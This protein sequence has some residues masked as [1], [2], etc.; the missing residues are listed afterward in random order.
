MQ[1]P[2]NW[3]NTPAQMG[4][5][6]EM[7]PP[8]GHIFKILRAFV[9]PNRNGNDMMEVWVDVAE[10]GQND[11][12]YRRNA[13]NRNMDIREKWPNDGIIYVNVYDKD[14]NANPRFKGFIKAVE[15]SNLSYAWNWDEMT[16]RGKL[17]G[18]I[19]RGEESES[20]TNGRIYTNCK[21]I[22]F[23]AAQDALE[24]AAPPKKLL[25]KNQP[26]RSNAAS[27]QTGGKWED[28]DPDS[29]PF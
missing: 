13:Q 17:I 22:A 11:G 16:L 12:F 3:E 14:G 2:R 28:D 27:A 24:K 9:R 19:C 25:D 4:G 5:E 8:G 6:F 23:C 21:I 1:K 29:L 26:A 20:T 18:G 15:Q 7:L 10:G